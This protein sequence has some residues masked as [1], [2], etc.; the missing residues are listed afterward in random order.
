MK[1]ILLHVHNDDVFEDRLQVAL[2]LCRAFDAHLTCIHVRP[3]GAYMPYDAISGLGVESIVLEDLRAQQEQAAEGLEKR[4]EREDVRWDWHAAD[5][6]VAQRI[7]EASA[8][9]DLIVLGQF[10]LDV[11][12]PNPA[13]PIVGD[14]A[15]RAGCP[16]LVIPKGV[17]SF[18][19]RKPIVIGWNGSPEAAHS[20][21]S[22]I[23]LLK[24]ASSVHIVSVSDEPGEY[25]QADANVYLSRHQVRSDI[26]DVKGSQR[27]A[28][29]LLHDFAVGHGA[30]CLVIGAYGHS[31]LREMLLGGA[32]RSLLA[33]SK[34]PLLLNH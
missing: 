4:M 24:L 27:G 32:T 16:V 22:A 1:S 34:I 19:P 21:R 7:V 10:S 29:T 11:K 28:A 5:G 26:H 30:S 6:D 18:T 14:V 2:D 9:A 8:L 31:R 25:P 23:D 12:S 3:T 17:H 13:L 33:K 20:V 15:L